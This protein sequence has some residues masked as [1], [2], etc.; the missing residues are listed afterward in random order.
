MAVLA[1]F[2][3][4]TPRYVA[5]LRS[6][7]WKAEQFR[8]Y[9]ESCLE[10]VLA[11]AARIS[12]YRE[13]FAARP[14]TG[15][16]ACLPI[17]SRAEVP[18][19]NASVR[20]IHPA[21]MRL[22]SD[23]SSGSTGLPVEFIFDGS[24]QRGRNAARARYLLANG[25]NPLQRTVWHYALNQPDQ[26][27]ADFVHSRFLPGVNFQHPSTDLDAQIARLIELDPIY[28]SIYPSNLEWLLRVIEKTGQKLRSIRLIFTGAEVVD[29]SLR[30]RTS[31]LLGARIADNYGS[32][33]AFLAW[34]C[35]R[36][37][38]HVNAEHV[39]IEIVDDNDRPVRPREMGRVI[40]TTLENRLMP[41]VRYEIGD[42]AV[43]AEGSCGCGRTL[44]LIGR[45]AGRAVDLFRMADGRIVSPYDLIS[46][47]K[48]KP[49]IRQ[50]QIVQQEFDRY[51][52]R[53]V[54]D[55]PVSA[56]TERWIRDKFCESLGSRVVVAFEPVPEIARTAAGK[57]MP[58]RSELSNGAGTKTR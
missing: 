39:V 31:A 16:F 6:Q 44:P 1:K 36:G 53:Y 22:L 8:D 41:L 24:H 42:Y 29:D 13:R 58:A 17:L 5:L 2:L 12:F 3:A 7:Y 10:K 37:S 23:S 25:W 48:W 30:E 46:L 11:A 56:E 55:R 33:E 21:S 20:S 14:K 51:R 43:A 27:D 52:L 35:P 32:T 45:I 34:Q 19:L 26:P 50:F 57:F 40:V 15:D 49:E 18:E 28:L 54:S 9:T 38:Y 4:A 47:I